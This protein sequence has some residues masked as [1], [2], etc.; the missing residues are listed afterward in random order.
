M[1]NSEAKGCNWLGCWD[2]WYQQGGGNWTDKIG[3]DVYLCGTRYCSA[4]CLT[5]NKKCMNHTIRMCLRKPN[6]VQLNI[7]AL[8]GKKEINCW[9][10]ISVKN[11]NRCTGKTFWLWP[12]CWS[13]KLQYVFGKNFFSGPNWTKLWYQTK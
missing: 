5:N 11:V 8:W 1:T 7:R 12:G 9:Y 6:K 2:S 4:K 13:V 3:P 10:M